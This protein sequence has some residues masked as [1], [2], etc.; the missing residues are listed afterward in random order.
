[1]MSKEIYFNGK[2]KAQFEIKNMGKMEYFFRGCLIKKENFYLSKYIYLICSKKEASLG[3]IE[4]SF[5]QIH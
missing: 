4:V 5:E 3:F 1:M 2:L